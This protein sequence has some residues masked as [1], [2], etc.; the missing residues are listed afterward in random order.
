M[1]IDLSGLSANTI[2]RFECLCGRDFETRQEYEEHLPACV[3]LYGITTAA[4]PKIM[5]IGG[6]TSSPAPS[7]PKP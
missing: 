1:S 4:A 7:D 2:T 3:F 6:T 5:V